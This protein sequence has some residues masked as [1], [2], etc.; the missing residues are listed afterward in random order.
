MKTETR[1]ALLL[2]HPTSDDYFRIAQHLREIDRKELAAVT[3]EPPHASILYSAFVSDP[4]WV[5]RR[6]DE[7]VAIGG[8][9]Q[10]LKDPELGVPWFLATESLSDREIRFWLANNSR[11]LIKEIQN[12]FSRLE[13]FIA[14]DNEV[15]REWLAWLGFEIGP[16]QC[17]GRNGEMMC[18]IYREADNV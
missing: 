4:C 1:P 18:R 5:L 16:P 17:L 8:V 3:N 14:A 10:S 7:P 6:G 9:A 13:N 2:A 12:K 15:T 11:R